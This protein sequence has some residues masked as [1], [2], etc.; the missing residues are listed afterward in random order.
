MGEVDLC[1]LPVNRS[2]EL[3]GTCNFDNVQCGYIFPSVLWD[4]HTESFGSVIYGS[5]SGN[6]GGRKKPSLFTKVQSIYVSI[7]FNDITTMFLLTYFV[8][9]VEVILLLRIR[10]SSRT[11]FVG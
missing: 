5:L 1:T 10:S 11:T 4:I 8:Y 7:Y 9:F 6:D 2:V 3:V